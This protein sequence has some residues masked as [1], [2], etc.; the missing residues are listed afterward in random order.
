MQHRYVHFLAAQIHILFNSS[1]ILSVVTS[2]QLP[3]IKDS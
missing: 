1:T 3:Y 2:T